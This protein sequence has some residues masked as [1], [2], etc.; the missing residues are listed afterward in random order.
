MKNWG[1]FGADGP[2]PRALIEMKNH[3]MEQRRGRLQIA[4]MTPGD[5][6]EK[7]SGEENEI[8]IIETFFTLKR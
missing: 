7:N 6:I 5:E 1:N 8:K 2:R 4:V 3:E